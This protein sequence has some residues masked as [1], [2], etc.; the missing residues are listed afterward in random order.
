MPACGPVREVAATPL[1]C[2]AIARSATDWSSPVE[3]S[4]SIS[5]GEGS[6]L[7]SS[8][9]LSSLSGCFP[10]AETVTTRPSPESWALFIRSATAFMCSVVA[11]ELPPYFWTIIPT[12]HLA[13]RRS[14]TRIASRPPGLAAA[15]DAVPRDTSLDE[16]GRDFP[17][18]M[19]P[20]SHDGGTPPL[21]E[22]YRQGRRTKELA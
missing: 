8:A 4:W 21:V 5:R 7:T 10:I 6:R 18:E 15:V 14:V 19:G 11:T 16:S 2:S 20:C 17:T 12:R 1:S 13:C 22:L 3:S 9:S